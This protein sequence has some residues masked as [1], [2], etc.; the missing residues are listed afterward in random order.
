MRAP[1]NDPTPGPAGA[2]PTGPAALLSPGEVAALFGV[3]VATVARWSNEGRLPALLTPGGH[4]RYRR[5]DVEALLGE[6]GPAA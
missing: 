6:P 3:H 5:A 4:R 2:T 1:T